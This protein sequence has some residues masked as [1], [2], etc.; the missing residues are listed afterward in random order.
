MTNIAEVVAISGN[1]FGPG[2][3]S[4]SGNEAGG[5]MAWILDNT[6][7]DQVSADGHLV[8]NSYFAFWRHFDY[9]GMLLG[10]T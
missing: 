3:W 10:E 2:L 1:Q 7:E 5:Y 4:V 9:S 6:L 8:G